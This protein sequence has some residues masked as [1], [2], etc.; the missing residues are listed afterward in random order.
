MH[1]IFKSVKIQLIA[2][3]AVFALYFVFSAE[4]YKF[5]AAILVAVFFALLFESLAVYLKT[6]K[7]H[8]T[9]SAAITG[10]IIGFVLSSSEPLWHIIAACA[11]AIGVKHILHYAKGKH[12]FNPAALGILLTCLLWGA[13]TQWA[14]TYL[15]YVLLPAGLYFAYR[16]KKLELLVGYFAATIL[17]FGVQ[18]LHQGH[19]LENV[20]KYLTYFYIFIMAIEPKT[21]PMTDMGKYIFGAVLGCLIF[22]FTQMGLRFDVELFSLLVM[23]AL[24]PV[25][26]KAKSKKGGRV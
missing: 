16:F 1:N 10:L 20:F 17:L 14:G 11:I 13:Y 15:W 8:L 9:E 21:T 12:V 25:L 5:L 18:A 22:I 24:V 23:N 2:F 4:N 3:L 26:N 7:F 19:S 6:K